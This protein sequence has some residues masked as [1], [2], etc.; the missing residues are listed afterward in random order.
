MEL[1]LPSSTNNSRPGMPKDFA[2]PTTQHS[3][4][5]QLQHLTAQIQTH[6]NDVEKYKILTNALITTKATLKKIPS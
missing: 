5:R 3:N 1:S 2:F 6:A 4:F